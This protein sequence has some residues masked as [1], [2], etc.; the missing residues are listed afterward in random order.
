MTF[1]GAQSCPRSIDA[2]HDFSDPLAALH[3]A[4]SI[5][6]PRKGEHTVNHCSNGA[7]TEM[8]EP[9][10]TKAPGHCAFHVR[11]PGL[12]H[13]PDDSQMAIENRVEREPGICGP[14]HDPHLYQAS[15]LGHRAHV[16]LKIW[17]TNKIDHDVDA[18]TIGGFGHDLG[19][20][21]VLVVNGDVD[22]E[23]TYSIKLFRFGRTDDPTTDGTSQLDSS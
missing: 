19:K 6:R 4:M 13:R 23:L 12:H 17:R 18:A 1:A 11:R 2:E 22:T 21:L 16:T 8:L 20:I 10:V 3:A 14:A 15:A 9:S 5:S 7:V